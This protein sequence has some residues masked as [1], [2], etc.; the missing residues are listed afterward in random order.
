M[1]SQTLL[2]NLGT[3]PTTK[4]FIDERTQQEIEFQLDSEKIKQ[5]CETYLPKLKENKLYYLISQRF[6]G[7]HQQILLYVD[8][9]G[10]DF[11]V[12]YYH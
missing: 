2:Q 6:W 12:D 11:F 8:I 9:T 5:F 1:D 3:L 7:I 4:I 10:T